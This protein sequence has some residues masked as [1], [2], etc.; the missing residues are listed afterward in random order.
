MSIQLVEIEKLKTN[1]K[2]PRYIRKK[3]F[4]KLKKSLQDKPHLL[5][6]NP[7][8]AT[9]DGT[10]I[11]GNQRYRA[12]LEIGLKEVPVIYSEYSEADN[13]YFA[14]LDNS[15]YGE[16]DID[17]LANEIEPEILEFLNIPFF[18]PE[19]EENEDKPLKL[20]NETCECC[21]K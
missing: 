19:P 20:E 5:N 6:L 2:N 14:L 18:F 8:K 15:H 9:P 4:Q 13:E 1:E 7:I 21:G 16:W 12:A 3:E 10:I 17:I 11:A